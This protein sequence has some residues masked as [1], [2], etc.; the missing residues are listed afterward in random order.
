MAMTRRV[1]VVWAVLIGLT[2]ASFI[3]GIEQSAGMASAAAVVI[4]AIALCKVRLI[5][6]HFMDLRAAPRTLRLMF[7]GYVLAVFTTLV[8]L[9]LV[10]S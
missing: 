7:D 4:I 5:G 1:T 2:F 8:M 3:V 10:V 6:K 9:G